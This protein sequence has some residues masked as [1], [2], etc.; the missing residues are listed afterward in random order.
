MRTTAWGI[1]ITLTSPN[2]TNSTDISTSTPAT[3]ATSSTSLFVRIQQDNAG[4]HGFN[5]F[6]GGKP[7]GH[8][9]RLVET[10]LQRGYCVFSQPRNSL[11]FNMLD[12]GF[13]N[14]IKSAVRQRTHEIQSLP[15]QTHGLIQQNMW[16]L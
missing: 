16:K 7:T 12:L 9:R 8:Q 1:P 10:M 11:E 15:N 3:S 14:S 4:G 13:W 2:A 6:Q 5:N